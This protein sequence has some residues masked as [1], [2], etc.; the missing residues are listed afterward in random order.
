MSQTPWR[1][2]G[3][4]AGAHTAP[5]VTSAAGWARL[6]VMLTALPVLAALALRGWC[7]G[8]GWGGQAPLWRACYSDLPSTL[9]ALRGDGAVSEPVLT[10]LALRLVAVPVRAADTSAQSTYVLLWA[11]VGLILLAVIAAATAAYRLDDPSRALLVVLCPVVPL[12]LLLSAEIV[13]VTLAVLALLAWRRRL[14]A[15]AG[16]LLALAVFSSSYA[17]VL[18]L[19]LLAVAARSG[20]SPR[21]VLAGLGTAAA[22]IVAAAA[23][24][25]ELD[26]ITGPVQAWWDAVPSYGSVWLLPSL[27]GYPLPT[28]LTPWLVLAGWAAAAALVLWHVSTARRTPATADVA[29]LGV[30]AVL[31]TGSAV[32]VQ[33]SLWLVPLVALSALPW[34]D[35]LVWAAAEVV[36][37]PMVWL[38]LGGLQEPDRGLPAGWYAFFLLLRLAAIGYLIWRVV[39]L[40]AEEP[41]LGGETVGGRGDDPRT[42]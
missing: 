15:A 41:Q 21:A 34:R 23:L 27:A 22:A 17:V 24:L 10:A 14:D 38:Y 30:A 5:R 31:V 36:Y 32:P 37:Y 42:G 40:A 26:R 25:G 11:L 8:N 7:L 3:G 39:D 12:T 19:A 6:A 16:V 33:A 20:R 35:M 2:I 9:T 18:V 28:W 13:G 29:L 4:P 1:V